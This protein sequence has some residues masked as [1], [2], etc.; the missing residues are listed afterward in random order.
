MFMKQ[1]DLLNKIYDGSRYLELFDFM[2]SVIKFVIGLNIW[3]EKSGFQIV[4]IIIWQ[5]SELIHII[6]RLKKK[7]QFFIML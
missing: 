3:S 4:F 7:C 1:M 5:V 2:G 6:L